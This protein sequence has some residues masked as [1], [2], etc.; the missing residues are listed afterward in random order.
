MLES[1]NRLPACALAASV[2]SL[3][4]AG[5]TSSSDG[6]PS[7]APP[8]DVFKAEFNTT[9]GALP[10]PVDLFFSGSTDGTLNLPVI[11]FRPASNRDALNSLDGWSTTAPITASFSMPLDGDSLTA[12]SVR[13]VEMYVSNTTKAPASGDEL[14]DGVP[15]PVRGILA[16]GVDYEATVSDD[17]DSNGRFL[18]ITPLKPLTPS[19]GGINIGY[20]VILT[21]GITNTD[22]AAATPDTQY[23]SYKDAPADCSS[24]DPATQLTDFSLCRLTKAHLQIAGAI[25]TPADSVVL[26]WGFSTQSV[27]DTLQVL[28]ALAPA[29][30]ITV[31]PTGLTTQAADPALQ[32]KANIWVGAT[33]VPYYLT[34]PATATDRAAVLT[35]FWTAAG[36]P[37]VPGLD[38]TSRHLTRFNPVP[39]KVADQ[40]IPVLM[41]VPNATAAGGLCAQ[42]A[43][44]WPVAVVQHGITGNRTQ[45]LAIADSFADACF[46]VV[47]IDLPLH[48]LVPTG[49]PTDAFRCAATTPN[50]VCLGAVER[51]F[52]VDLIDNTTGASTSDGVIDSSGAHMINLSSPLTSRDNL[53]QA[54]ADLDV[55]VKTLASLNFAGDAA[56]DVDPTRIHLV[57]LSL[58]AITGIASA[59]FA[60]FDTF[61]AAVPGGVLTRLLLDSAAFGPRLKAGLSGFGLIENSYV[62]NLFVRDVQAAADAADAI[63]H[64]EA[65]QEKLPLHLTKV[66]DDGVV[67]NSATDRLIVAGGLAKL[68][69]V[70]PNPVGPGTGAYTFFSQ[71]SHGTL[72]DPTA[73]LA[74]TVEMQKQAVNF[75]ATAVA[76]GGPFVVIEDVTVLDID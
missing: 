66:L 37:A 36:P 70:G 18:K 34:P 23:A 14:P 53:R 61:T 4:L 59:Q 65:A 19:T 47:A 75:A 31:V 56:A 10:Y 32:G 3:V 68:T 30:P 44:G 43:A 6:D 52:D 63:N 51:T 2:A 67:P 33:T 16:P 55:L 69:T 28:H 60:D 50:P 73:S 9:S 42:P 39:A 12:G 76:P 1:R 71:G 25:G 64:I 21:N 29:Q 24:F 58:G 49:G 45:A 41:T 38:P 48:G 5:C 13:V 27:D 26:T 46:V 20:L 8:S 57:G 72:F 62:Y 11:A 15:S 35:K 17:I 74:A 7:P 54:E 22:G 40:L